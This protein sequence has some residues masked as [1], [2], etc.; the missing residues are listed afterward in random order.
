[1]KYYF[2]N[3]RDDKMEGYQFSLNGSDDDFNF[4]DDAQNFS[5]MVILL[6]CFSLWFLDV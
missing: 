2:I 4:N 3:H 5:R 1:M 6:F